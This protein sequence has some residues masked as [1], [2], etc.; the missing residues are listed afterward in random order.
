MLPLNLIYIW[1][2]KFNHSYGAKKG[3]LWASMSGPPNTQRLTTL[4][5]HFLQNAFVATEYQRGWLSLREYLSSF[6][7]FYQRD[8]CPFGSAESYNWKIICSFL[9]THQPFRSPGSLHSLTSLPDLLYSRTQERLPG[10]RVT[11]KGGPLPVISKGP[12]FLPYRGEISPQFPM[13]FGHLYKGA[14][15]LHL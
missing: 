7:K 11:H 4:G 10:R 3:Y 12:Q 1:N 8:C 2:L 5:L 15:K 9:K 6:R 14:P 13:I